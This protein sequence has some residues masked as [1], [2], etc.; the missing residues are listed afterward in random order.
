MRFDDSAT[1]IVASLTALDSADYLKVIIF[2]PTQTTQTD[3]L[4]TRGKGT[5]GTKPAAT[6]D[7][8]K[9]IRDRLRLS[10]G[11]LNK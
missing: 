6:G 5:E 4:T 1:S 2:L 10:R 11:R 9:G 7:R 3:V 8:N